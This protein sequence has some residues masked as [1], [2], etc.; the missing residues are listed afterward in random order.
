MVNRTSI[1]DEL[2][3]P[4]P[5]ALVLSLLG[6]SGS[7]SQSASWTTGSGPRVECPPQGVNLDCRSWGGGDGG[8]ALIPGSVRAS[9]LAHAPPGTGQTDIAVTPTMASMQFDLTLIALGLA[10][11]AACA[12]GP[13][14]AGADEIFA[15][16]LDL[17]PEAAGLG[18]ALGRRDYRTAGN[19]LLAFSERALAVI[20]EKFAG[21]VVGSTLCRTASAVPGLAQVRLGIAVAKAVVPVANL[22]AALLLVPPGTVS[23]VYAGGGPGPTA[24]PTPAPTATAAAA[25][26]DASWVWRAVPAPP[27]AIDRHVRLADGRVL[28]FEPRFWPLACYAEY[29]SPEQPPYG[30]SVFDP[31]TDTWAVMASAPLR[32]EM[33][34][35]MS[36]GRVLVIG[37]SGWLEGGPLG[38]TGTPTEARIFDLSANRWLMAPAPTEYGQLLTLADGRTAMVGAGR[39]DVLDASATRWLVLGRLQSQ[40]SG[41]SSWLLSDG[42]LL[43]TGVSDEQGHAA[44]DELFDPATGRSVSFAGLRTDQY[45]Y[46]LSV[47]ARPGGGANALVHRDGSQMPLAATLDTILPR[48]SKPTDFGASEAWAADLLRTDGTVLE[49]G[50]GANCFEETVWVSD[51]VRLFHLAA[52][53][54]IDLAPMPVGQVSPDLLALEDGSILAF[55]GLVLKEAGAW[56]LAPA[57]GPWVFGPPR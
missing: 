43:V 16:A 25:R 51:Q 57:G 20:S 49:A 1:A 3:L 45:E 29:I 17:W 18:G 53:S 21:S 39:V 15:L 19:E 28:F 9:L 42:R 41:G 22:A 26:P 8:V 7:F 46:A 13:V 36:D 31:A 34:T 56:E 52:G 27:F 11:D 2:H 32:V 5:V 12:A 4:A 44:P 14:A 33:A 23:V 48:W 10:L 35:L 40:A 30:V 37:D 38:A 24:G 50:G 6:F 47:E 55:N 54:S